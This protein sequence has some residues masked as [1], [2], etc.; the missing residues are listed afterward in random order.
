MS[1]L[2]PCNH[3]FLEKKDA[4][5]HKLFPNQFSEMCFR[6]KALMQGNDNQENKEMVDKFWHDNDVFA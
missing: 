4:K 1:Q 6:M 5:T 3:I 2:L